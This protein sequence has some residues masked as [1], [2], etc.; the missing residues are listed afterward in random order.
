MSK[1]ETSN[2]SNYS[3]IYAADVV[4]VANMLLTVR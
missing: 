1:A 3:I 4:C 2:L